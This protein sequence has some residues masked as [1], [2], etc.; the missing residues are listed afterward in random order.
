MKTITLTIFGLTLITGALTLGV[1]L[2]NEPNRDRKLTIWLEDLDSLEWSKW[3]QGAEAHAALPRL[4]AL[5][6]DSAYNV[7][8]Q[9]GVAIDR[10]VR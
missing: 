2:P 3:N 6:N 9:A 1:L 10:I 4:S 7:R 8:V 5:T